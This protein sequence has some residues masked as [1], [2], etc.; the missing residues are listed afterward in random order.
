MIYA[1][2]KDS[3]AQREINEQLSA[4]EN[5]KWY[6]RLMIISLSAKRHTVKKLTEMF[7]LGE[8]TIRRYIH[9]YN[10]DGLSGLRPKRTTR[11]LN[12]CPRSSQ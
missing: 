6:R 4:T 3:N 12:Q 7:Q 10:Q 1:E 2:V 9:A 8:A 5:K 11:A